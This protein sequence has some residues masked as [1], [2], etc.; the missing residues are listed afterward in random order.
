MRRDAESGVTLVSLPD[1]DP[2]LPSWPSEQPGALRHGAR[3]RR[4]AA[5]RRRCVDVADLDVAEGTPVLDGDGALVGI[6]ARMATR[7]C[8]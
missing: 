8:R 4:R 5:G 7:A 1:A 6:C 2:R 3:P